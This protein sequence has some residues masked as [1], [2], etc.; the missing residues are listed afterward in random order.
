L[1]T[2][3]EGPRPAN[4]DLWTRSS[5]STTPG[6]TKLLAS[7]V[8]ELLQVSGGG[9]SEPADAVSSRRKAQFFMG[10]SNKRAK[11]VVLHIHGLDDYVS[12]TPR[13]PRP[14]TGS[15][16]RLSLPCR[17]AGVSVRRPC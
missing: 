13:R 5:R 8:Y 11:T 6:E 9:G 16:L 7:E 1:S 12:R 15:S 17:A 10:A 4:Q 14:Q 3:P 2:S